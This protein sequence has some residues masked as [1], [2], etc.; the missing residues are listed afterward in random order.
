MIIRN[1]LMR[2]LI[3]GHDNKKT[4][5]VRYAITHDFL[6]LLGISRQEDL[7]DFERLNSNELLQ[8]LLNM[9]SEDGSEGET[10]G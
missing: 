2:G 6:S 8:K 1:L 10:S 3:E 9:I 5:Q 7:P 4:G